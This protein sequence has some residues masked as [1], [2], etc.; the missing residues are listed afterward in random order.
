MKKLIERTGKKEKTTTK[1]PHCWPKSQELSVCN[2]EEKKKKK[3]LS[4][5]NV[6]K[7]F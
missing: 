1:N 6:F 4:F 5:Q 3:L 2:T 7:N